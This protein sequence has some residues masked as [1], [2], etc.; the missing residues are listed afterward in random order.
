[1]EPLE[2]RRVLA[3]SFTGTYVQNFDTLPASGTN[4]TWTNDTTL[5]GWSLFRQPA[6]GT[7]ITAVNA[8]DG[9]SNAGSF[10]S[11]GT[12]SDR[13]LGGVGSG[14]AYF[15]SPAS[16]TVA[17]WIALALTNNTGATINAI[18]LEYDGEQWRDGGNTSTQTMKLEFGYGATFDAVTAWIAPGGAFDF[19]SPT[20]SAT[21]EQLNGNALKN[22]ETRGGVMPTT[23]WTPGST[24]WIRWAET[25]DV[26]NDH[27]LSIDDLSISAVSAIVVTNLN[28]SGA[29]S[30]RDAIAL[31]DAASG[32]DAI[33]FSHTLHGG[34]I[35]LQ[36]QLVVNDADPLTI[37]GPGSALLSIEGGDSTRLI[38]SQS[39]LTIS[40]LLLRDG[41]V[42]GNDD[43]GAIVSF[44]NLIAAGLSISSNS[45]HGT[46]T[47]SGNTGGG[48]SLFIG[49]GERVLIDNCLFDSNEAIFGENL[50][51]A[52]YATSGDSSF[53]GSLTV[54]HSRFVD[55]RAAAGGAVHVNVVNADFNDCDFESNDS[56]QGGAV[57]AYSAT[58]T[59]G[60]CRFF[61]NY[62]RF[63]GAAV[64]VLQ[65]FGNDII[66]AR[67]E[68]ESNFTGIAGDFPS[69]FR[70]GAIYANAGTGGPGASLRIEECLFDD[71]ESDL[72]GA[73][74]A[75]GTAAGTIIIEQSLF[76]NNRAD[77][78]GALLLI[79]PVNVVNCTLTANHAT[80]AGEGAGA[81]VGGGI[82]HPDGASALI[83]GCTI[84]GNDA[85]NSGGGV[86]S[87]FPGLTI[88]N[89]IIAQNTDLG[90]HPEIGHDLRGHNPTTVVR[91]SLIG[92]NRASNLAEAPLGSPDGNGNLVG[93]PTLGFIN[94]LLG[95]LAENGGLTQT[96][97][98][99]TGS[100][101]IQA[102][103]PNFDGAPL[104]D[105]RGR[106]RVVYSRIDM[107]AY[108]YEG[109]TY[110]GPLVVGT[111]IDEFDLDFS[112]ADLSLR[113]ALF[114]AGE[115]PGLQTV[116]FAPT[117]NG[118]VITLALGELDVRGDILVTGPGATQ[119]AISG[120]DVWRIFNVD[121][122]TSSAANVEITGITLRNGKAVSGFGGAIY[123]NENLTLRDAV[124]RANVADR[125]GGGIA[126]RGGSL[127]V[128]NTTIAENQSSEG[129]GGI[130]GSSGVPLSLVGSSVIGNHTSRS[131]P[132]NVSGGGIYALSALSVL[133]STIADN[134]A[135]AGG[136][137]ISSQ[138]GAPVTI[139]HSTITNNTAAIEMNTG[140]T[141]G[142]I[143]AE[144]SQVTLDHAILAGNSDLLGQAPDISVAPLFGSISAR[145]SFIGDATGSGLTPLPPGVT[146]ANGNRIGP[147]Y[148]GI[149]F[150][151]FVD[152]AAMG[153]FELAPF[154]D[155]FLFEY[156]LDGGPWLPL[157]TS[158]VDEAVT[159]NYTL[160][161]GTVVNLPDPLLV[162]GVMLNNEFQGI[163]AM[164][165]QGGT[166]L[167]I[168]FTGG[169]DGEEAFAWRNL[170]VY[171]GVNGVFDFDA[172]PMGWAVASTV[173]IPGA[174]DKFASFS[175]PDPDYTIAG[176]MFGFR[177]RVNPGT[178][179]LPF[180]MADDSAGTFP[181]DMLGIIGATDNDPIFGVVDTVNGVGA[182]LHTATW[183]FTDPGVPI[184]PLLADLA[185]NGGPT[186]THLPL[187]GSPV[188]NAGDPAF[189]GTP[190]ADQR[191]APFYRVA[192]GRTDI[193]AV[194]LQTPPATSADFVFDGAINGFDF[195]A[196]QRG[197]GAIGA[198]ATLANGNADGDD[199]VDGD[200]LAVWKATFGSSVSAAAA[201][202]AAGDDVAHLA[203]SP[204]AVDAYLA[205]QQMSAETDADAWR[206]LGK[207][208]WAR[209][210]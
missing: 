185:D 70:G 180:A 174:A 181:G 151:V 10:Y 149:S 193:G 72:G 58:L 114:F 94:P 150:W 126:A 111:A 147:T 106:P 101:A 86:Y 34:T 182:D 25:N 38:N 165:P 13:A 21:A 163:P 82:N 203:L 137:G 133:N 146:D 120:S 105:Q 192:G 23:A 183:T 95:P 168:R 171:R 91:Y 164:I 156:S 177:S 132:L 125:G 22:F 53:G 110:N 155:R 188:L 160:E 11:F 84:V 198:T 116:S 7:A 140:G 63:D 66:I 15:G 122:G 118:E 83:E 178:P 49:V 166:Q 88:E 41:F 75:E 124:V 51:G 102:G 42:L 81:F 85:G 142:G 44:G 87:N 175:Q 99:L 115:R 184:D 158:T 109:L 172:S 190:V 18:A 59:L 112:P 90:G 170:Q 47:M 141:G 138:Y 167:T 197:F 14:G 127:N 8:S 12:L 108:E 154:E 76:L 80:G 191:G 68:F 148:S 79:G 173:A 100:P 104:T 9:T 176:D 209:G 200:D 134:T 129:G 113:E 1:M 196:W 52:L 39:D 2:D 56:I 186:K 36:S 28:N 33:V 97:A 159:Q 169:S 57:Y 144:F 31:A 145:Y 17:G 37:A 199:D 93:G 55:S 194:E 69:T 50:G 65:F 201:V 131:N 35:H 117:L 78:G 162:N 210:V 152:M 123:S 202:R 30:L 205:L 107:G 46:P 40:G 143:E 179:S 77:A 103:K 189:A 45:S 60:D 29:G 19:I 207:R 136:G 92:D 16:N 5:P 61:N 204:A 98:L 73:V 67:S 157:F 43:G 128:V 195:L 6:P 208:R 54:T 3:V 96:M 130:Y 48:V 206:P 139:R 26:G 24:L 27:G 153:D 20:H 89:S 119:L 135:D 71:N 121:D 4:L 64:A 32:A 62:A 161:S 74:Y 187:A